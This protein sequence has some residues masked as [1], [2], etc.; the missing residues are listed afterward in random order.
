MMRVGADDRAWGRRSSRRPPPRERYCEESP[1]AALTAGGVTRK[2][3]P[4][5]Q[6]A[7]YD[8]VARFESLAAKKSTSSGAKMMD[9]ANAFKRAVIDCLEC[10]ED[11]YEAGDSMRSPSQLRGVVDLFVVADRAVDHARRVAH[12]RDLCYVLATEPYAAEGV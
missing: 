4:S 2:G 9:A 6:D 3:V 8:A 11:E 7:S 1:R 5:V 12:H 10:W